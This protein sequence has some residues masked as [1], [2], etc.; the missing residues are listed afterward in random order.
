MSEWQPIETALKDRPVIIQVTDE[1]RDPIV[2]EA[3]WHD[4]GDGGDWWWANTSPG[5]YY[6]GPISEMNFGKPT[7]WMPLPLP[8]GAKP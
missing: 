5:D 1:T 7:H 3:Q 2:G 4:D 8:Y 6:S